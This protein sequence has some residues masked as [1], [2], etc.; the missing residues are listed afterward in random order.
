MDE[1]EIIVDLVNQATVI[2]KP[3]LFMDSFVVLLV[4]LLA[5]LWLIPIMFLRS[6]LDIIE[7]VNIFHY[8]EE[9]VGI[10]HEF[11]PVVVLKPF[12]RG[13][14]LSIVLLSIFSPTAISSLLRE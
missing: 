1:K 10:D 13:R 5:Y 6:L 3:G 7:H 14:I 11:I 9:I 12:L 2:F 8:S 4:F